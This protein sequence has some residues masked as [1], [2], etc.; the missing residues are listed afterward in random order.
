MP[1][2]KSRLSNGYTAGYITNA[3]TNSPFK[4]KAKERC[5]PQPKHSTPKNFLFKQGSMKSSI[6]YLLFET[7]IFLE[8]EILSL[9]VIFTT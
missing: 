9:V 7:V 2:N 8:N 6:I 5:K 3:A 4:R 1:T